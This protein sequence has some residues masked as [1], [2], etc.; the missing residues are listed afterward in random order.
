MKIGTPLGVPICQSPVS[1]CMDM[2]ASMNT[3]TIV[4]RVI[5]AV[6]R[7]SAFCT[8]ISNR[9]QIR[10]FYTQVENSIIQTR[11]VIE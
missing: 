3:H 1:M 9:G 2:V 10:L 4:L 5:P 8:R 11:Q 6:T 7:N